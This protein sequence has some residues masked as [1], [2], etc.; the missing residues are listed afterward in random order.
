MYWKHRGSLFRTVSFRL[1]I[2]YAILF[3]VVSFLCGLA[4]DSLLRKHLDERANKNLLEEAREFEGLYFTQ[5][6]EAFRAELYHDAEARGVTRVFS[7]L[8]SPEGEVVVTTD[9]SAWRDLEAPPAI[10]SDTPNGAVV[11]DTVSVSEHKHGVRTILLKLSDGSAIQVGNTLQDNELFIEEY[12]KVFWFSLLLLL[13]CGVVVGGIIGRHAMKGVRRVIQTANQIGQANLDR[14]VPLGNEGQEIEL[15][16]RSFNEML[17]RIQAL[18][19]EMKEVT[20]SVAHDLRSPIARIRIIAESVLAA[21][22]DAETFREMAGT[23][24]EESDRL[25]EMINTMLE[26]AQTDSG[27]SE[28]SRSAVNMVEIIKDAREIFEPVAADAGV[29]LEIRV[30]REPLTL[31]GDESRLQRVLANLLDNAIKYTGAGGEIL[32][33]AQASNSDVLIEVIDTGAGIAEE[34]VPHVFDPFYRGDRSRSSPGNG[35][36]LS[37]AQSIVRA[38]GGAISVASVPGKGSTFTVSLPRSITN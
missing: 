1:T 16:A 4:V 37:L 2:W 8:L 26:I 31:M 24:V 35:L 20:N 13:L 25:V 29:R 10:L 21:D 36:G 19:Q 9:M 30:P 32:L 33:A 28:L 3:G 14:R 7:R 5:T 34:D 12:R 38:H 15:L 23:V 18:V 17:D 11:F 27:V 22:S 6:R